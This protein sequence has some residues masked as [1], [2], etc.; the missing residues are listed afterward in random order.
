MAY[1][2]AQFYSA[3]IFLLMVMINLANKVCIRP[4]LTI[5]YAHQYDIQQWV[6][7]FVIQEERVPVQTLWA[8]E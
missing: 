4:C 1:I 3:L 6:H 2:V 8:W 7:F 5:S